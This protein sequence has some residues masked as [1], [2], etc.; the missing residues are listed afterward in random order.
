MPQLTIET[1][2]LVSNVLRMCTKYKIERPCTDILQRIRNEWPSTLTLHTVKMDAIAREH[3]RGA[4]FIMRNGQ[5]V[6]NPDYAPDAVQEDLI[7]NPANVISLLRECNLGSKELLAPLFYALSR[8]T[9]QFGGPAIGHHI[10]SLSQADTE[11]FILGLERLRMEHAALVVQPPALHAAHAN[12]CGV[13]LNGSWHLVATSLL[14]AHGG[15]KQPIED[16]RSI[17]RSLRA[18]GRLTATYGLCPRCAEQ[19]LEAMEQRREKLWTSLG[20]WFEG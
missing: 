16:W 8:T 15:S 4:Q 10:A 18:D 13:H 17:I 6:A 5:A 1:W 9:W 2:P 11:R 12:S 3:N 7:V 19:V 20:G 14:R